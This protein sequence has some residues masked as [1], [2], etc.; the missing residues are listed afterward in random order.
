MSWLSAAASIAGGFLGRSAQNDAN[1]ANAAIAG[2][3]LKFQ[4]EFARQ[5]IQMRVA[6]AKKA[7]IHPL[8]ALGANLPTY[9]P[10]PTYV[11]AGTQL[12]DAVAEAGQNIGRAVD[13]Q[14][15][16]SERFQA[17]INELA[18]E[19]GELE[20][21]LLRS[22]LA[23]NMPGNP[24]MQ[25]S[26]SSPSRSRPGR[27]SVPGQETG[28]LSGSGGYTAVVNERPSTVPGSPSQEAGPTPEVLWVQTGSGLTPQ[29]SMDAYE[30]AD[31]GNPGALMWYFRNNLLPTF[32]VG[33]NPPPAEYLPD[34]AIGWRFN[35][36]KQEYVP[37]YNWVPGVDRLYGYD[38]TGQSALS[39]TGTQGGW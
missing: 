36:L 13:A 22:Q 33:G 1:D 28:V 24:P 3:N 10:S 4:R 17:R 2:A 20:N 37:V 19:R 5:G 12:G 9:S 35:P 25:A 6:D 27:P 21:A 14:R 29:P 8:Y 32:G 31:I 18:V 11:G 38:R 7:G 30:D 34:G 23:T 16:D 39:S 15:T 26:S